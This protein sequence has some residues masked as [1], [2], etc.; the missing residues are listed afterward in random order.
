[1]WLAQ[2]GKFAILFLVI[3]LISSMGLTVPLYLWILFVR[4]SLLKAPGL[5]FLL[6]ILRRFSTKQNFK[7]VSILHSALE[8]VLFISTACIVMVIMTRASEEELHS[9]WW[10]L[11]ISVSHIPGVC[12]IICSC[13]RM[14]QLVL[15]SHTFMEC[16]KWLYF[17]VTFEVCHLV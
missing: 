6:G 13:V 2:Q 5:P 3:Q 9:R 11:V 14:C 8:K 15:W 10:M 7:M 12:Q 1:M 17:L 16:A 4:M